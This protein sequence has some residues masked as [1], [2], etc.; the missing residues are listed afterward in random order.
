MKKPVIIV[1]IFIS[2]LMIT[3]LLVDYVTKHYTIFSSLDFII[4]Y[5]GFDIAISHFLSASVPLGLALILIFEKHINKTILIVIIT[6]LLVRTFDS[7][8]FLGKDVI[9]NSSFIDSLPIKYTIAFYALP[10]FFVITFITISFYI[11]KY[12]VLSKKSEN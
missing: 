3:F 7:I 4:S 11:I 5:Y 12:Y 6:L 10:I 8:L 2:L 9:N 1:N